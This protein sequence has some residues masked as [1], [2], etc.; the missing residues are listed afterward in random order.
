MFEKDTPSF[1]DL[2][3]KPNKIIFIDKFQDS[4]NRGKILKEIYDSHDI[5]IIITGSSSI[6]LTVK[7][8]KYLV[9][10]IF[11]FELLPFNFREFLKTKD[12]K[13]L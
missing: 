9:G 12:K 1:I 8:L 13:Y 2:Y 5:K 4:Q 11:T 6:D 3:V 7:A 10:R